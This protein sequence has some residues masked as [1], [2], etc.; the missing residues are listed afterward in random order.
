MDS[1]K[2]VF[3]EGAK[4]T[5]IFL[6]FCL[7]EGH[8]P[9]TLAGNAPDLDVLPPKEFMESPHGA[10][11]ADLT[12]INSSRNGTVVRLEREHAELL[13]RLEEHVHRLEEVSARISEAQCEPPLWDVVDASLVPTSDPGES[14]EE[15]MRR[16][17]LL[18]TVRLRGAGSVGAGVLV[19]SRLQS[20]Q[21]AYGPA[22]HTTFVLTAFHVVA[23]VLGGWT[24]QSIED[25]YIPQEGG[26]E[27]FCCSATMVLSNPTWD[28]ALLRLNTTRRFSHVASM[29]DPKG[30]SEIGVFRK[31]YVVGYPLGNGPLFSSG[32]ISSTGEISP[33]SASLRWRKFWM[34]NAPTIFGNSGG[35]V[36][37]SDSCELIGVSSSIYTYRRNTVVPH[38]SLFV[39]LNV[40]CEWLDRE[41]YTF[42]RRSL[43]I[44][45]AL[46]GRLLYN[47]SEHDSSAPTPLSSVAGKN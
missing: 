17:M 11:T 25:V 5:A 34:H 12:R 20:P 30:V 19:Y 1:A 33:S 7:L 36:Y 44:P 42:L 8:A 15:R 2:S 13:E 9:E 38:M 39:P 35:G 29:M 41:G 16:L 6:V 31:A 22:V 14:R 46:R 23:D 43:P 47:G 26:V 32:E 37:A 3:A 28:L 24:D 21:S 4:L 10:P 27:S 40:I 18:P 45:P